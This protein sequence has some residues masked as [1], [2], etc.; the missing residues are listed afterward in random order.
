VGPGGQREREESSVP[1]RA[2]K[3]M[4]RGLAWF[5]GRN[6]APGPLLNKQGFS[7][8]LFLFLFENLCK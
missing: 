6:S 1:V 5:L 3:E 7:Y 4:G 2:P 8:F